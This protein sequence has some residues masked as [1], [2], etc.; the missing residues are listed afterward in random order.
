LIKRSLLRLLSFTIVFCTVPFLLTGCGKNFY[1]AGR[2]LP[3]SQLTNRV[4]IAIQ[5]PSAFTN[6]ALSFVDAFYDIRHAYNNVNTT[7]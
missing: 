3:P 6:G 1:F 2:T 4:L 7:F 5:N